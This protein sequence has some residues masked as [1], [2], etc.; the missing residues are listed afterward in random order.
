MVF[1]G[2]I[3]QSFSKVLVLMNFQLHKDY[4]ANNLCLK[5]QVKNNHCKGSC[6]L[7][8]ELDKEEKKEQG[9]AGN[10]K[11]LKEFQGF[12]QHQKLFS[13]IPEQN[14]SI[15]FV[16]YKIPNTISTSYSIFHPPQSL[17]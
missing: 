13:F 1:T 15:N 14:I 7:K 17:I 16:P 2:I 9:P 8:K 12:C 3:C 4:I 6:H 10:L 5:K 11:D